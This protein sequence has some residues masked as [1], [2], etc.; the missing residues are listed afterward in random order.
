[1]RVFP[2]PPHNTYYLNA[3][4]EVHKITGYNSIRCVFLGVDLLIELIKYKLLA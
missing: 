2:P 4:I 1:M 3:I